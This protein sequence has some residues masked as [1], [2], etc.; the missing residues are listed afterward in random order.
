[1]FAKVISFLRI[2]SIKKGV[3]IKS[4][5]PESHLYTTNRFNL[6]PFYSFISLFPTYQS[7]LVFLGKQIHSIESDPADILLQVTAHRISYHKFVLQHS[8]L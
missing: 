1:M 5:L 3:I 7:T 6:L 8:L 4:H 2:P